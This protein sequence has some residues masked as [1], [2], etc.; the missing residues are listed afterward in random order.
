VSADAPGREIIRLLDHDPLLAAS[1]PGVL[2]GKLSEV[3]LASALRVRAGQ[4]FAPPRQPAGAVGLVLLEG[5]VL[6]GLAVGGRPHAIALGPGDILEWWHEGDEP[7][8]VEPTFEIVGDAL[9]AVLGRRYVQAADRWPQ[10]HAAMAGRLSRHAD[11]VSALAAVM[12]QPRVEMRVLG[13]LWHLARRWGHVEADGVAVTLSVTHEALGRLVGARRPSVTLALTD[14]VSAGAVSRR[15][16]RTWVLAPE[17]WK[18]LELPRNPM[19]AASI[20]AE[21]SDA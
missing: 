17:S 7:A 2:R 3:L 8:L 13:L 11:E 20:R 6:R 10:L 16:D 19:D 18:L 1:L 12:V 15:Q 21:F 5:L 9:I 14:L 4:S